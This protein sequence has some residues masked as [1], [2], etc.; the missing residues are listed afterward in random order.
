[1]KSYFRYLQLI[2]LKDQLYVD[3]CTAT[4]IQSTLD[5]TPVSGIYL[6]KT[7]YILRITL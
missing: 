2:R 3:L 7:K 4:Q 6:C 5:E 1:M